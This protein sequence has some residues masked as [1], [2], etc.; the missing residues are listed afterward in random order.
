[1]DIKT[2]FENA[3]QAFTDKI[4]PDPNVRAVILYGS[5][6]N[7]TVW[8]KSDIDIIVL[9]REIKL[10]THEFCIEE[11][12]LILNVK[13][14]V[15]FGFKRHIEG[16]L[17][18]GWSHSFYHK[19]RVVYAKDDS[20]RDFIAEFQGSMGA[21]DQALS[22]FQY[23]T[24]LVG[25]MEKIE[26]WLTVKDDPLYAQFWLLK[27]AEA[28]AN[29]RLVL[30]GKPPSREALLKVMEYAPQAVEHIYLKPMQGE[31]A[32]DEVWEALRFFKQFLTD[33]LEMLKQPV[34]SY[35]AGGE[36]RTVTSL[37][38]HFRLTAHEIYHV[39]QFLEEAGVVARVTEYTRITPKSRDA[40]EEVA[41][42]YIENME[43]NQW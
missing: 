5:M 38:K 4:K 10:P 25:D 13:L 1:M 9:V 43:A 21:D 40:V 34:V 12:G 30:D 20:L 8:E 2:R 18:G 33:N 17:G 42:M 31:M 16:S 37:V 24:W 27:T 29:M 32:C 7:D 3:L 26:K 39:F 41:F 36:V 28:Y 23:A 14:V 15:E 6:A 11:D 22:L 35:M 19:A